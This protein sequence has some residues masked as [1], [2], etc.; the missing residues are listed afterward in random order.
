MDAGSSDDYTCEIIADHPKFCASGGLR[1]EFEWRICL[2][3]RA[4]L[5]QLNRKW[6]KQI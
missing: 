3:N 1:D 2:R 4:A 5:F 6:F